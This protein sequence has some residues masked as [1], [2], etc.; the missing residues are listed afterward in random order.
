MRLTKFCAC[1]SI[2]RPES[3]LINLNLEQNSLVVA[4]AKQH[5]TSKVDTLQPNRKTIAIMAEGGIDRKAEERMEFTT[6]KDVTVAPTFQDSKLPLPMIEQY[7]TVYS[8]L[9]GESSSW[10][11]CIWLRIPFCSTIPCDCPDLQR[12]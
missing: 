11:L 8:A 6:S 2:A 3:T 1:Q 10:Y 4:K 7:L 12:P 9:E 5:K